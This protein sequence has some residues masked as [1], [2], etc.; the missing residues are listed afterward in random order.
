MEAAG[1]KRRFV[2]SVANFAGV[3]AFLK[4][5]SRLATLPSGL[6]VSVMRGFALVPLPV[7][8]DGASFAMFMAWH[9]RHALDP[10]HMLVRSLL[11]REAAKLGRV[12]R[13]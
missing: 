3:P 7:Q 5:S 6:S 12:R 9:R 11:A 13:R 1:H 10:A 2:V 4:G 8:I